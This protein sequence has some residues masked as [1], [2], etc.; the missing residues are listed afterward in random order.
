MQC[1]EVETQ[2]TAKNRHV[3]WST[4][5]GSAERDGIS[6]KT[7]NKLINDDTPY[8]NFT[9]FKFEIIQILFMPMP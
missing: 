7:I 8:H 3:M 2:F 6:S 4:M 9:I 5:A 1:S